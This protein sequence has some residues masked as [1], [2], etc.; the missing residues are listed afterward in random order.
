[1]EIDGGVD[2]EKRSRTFF[3]RRTNDL[4]GLKRFNDATTDTFCVYDSLRLNV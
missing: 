2:W 4:S 1:M 3:V